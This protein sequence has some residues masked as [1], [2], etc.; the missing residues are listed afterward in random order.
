[1][2]AGQNISGRLGRAFHSSHL[3]DALWARDTLLKIYLKSGWKRFLSEHVLKLQFA[4]FKAVNKAG[5]G[6]GPIFLALQFTVQFGM[7]HAKRRQMT[8]VHLILLL[9][10]LDDL[11][12]Q[13]NH[14]SSMLSAP[15][16]SA[17]PTMRTAVRP[18]SLF[19]R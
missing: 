19:W 6:K 12:M 9:M 14:E 16:F 17:C 3:A 11:T 4:L 15:N 1:M 2:Q 10:R 5:I 13:V 7:F 18:T 8:V